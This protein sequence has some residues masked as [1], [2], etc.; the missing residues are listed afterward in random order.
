MCRSC[1][2]KSKKKKGRLICILTSFTFLSFTHKY[3]FA[4]DLMT[5]ADGGATAHLQLLFTLD[6]CVCMCAHLC[7]CVRASDLRSKARKHHQPE[8]GF[9]HTIAFA[10]CSASCVYTV[11]CFATRPRP[12]IWKSG[13]IKLHETHPTTLV[14]CIFTQ[15]LYNFDLPPFLKTANV[16][17]YAFVHCGAFSLVHQLWLCRWRLASFD[18]LLLC[19][20]E[21]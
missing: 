16:S 13:V 14:E 15:V 8:P 12:M 9:S 4:P 7:V 18:Y 3:A 21:V 6:L 2:S 1:L 19:G 20:G 10:F 17:Y 5:A 11:R